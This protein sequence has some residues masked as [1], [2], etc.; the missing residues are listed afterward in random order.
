MRSPR[1]DSKTI[2]AIIDGSIFLEPFGGDVA[3]V[4]AIV[5]GAGVVGKIGLAVGACVFGVAV[6]AVVSGGDD[7]IFYLMVFY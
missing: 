6:G 3:I 2:S 7:D 4:V 1:S 5:V